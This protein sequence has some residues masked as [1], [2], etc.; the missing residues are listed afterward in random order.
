MIRVL[1][2]GSDTG[3]LREKASLDRGVMGLGVMLMSV[4]P[5][6]LF[7]KAP[8]TL[9]LALAFARFVAMV[10]EI[11]RWHGGR[12]PEQCKSMICPLVR[13]QREIRLE[14]QEDVTSRLWERVDA[15]LPTITSCTKCESA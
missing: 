14:Y 15:M 3:V 4:E 5:L 6:A 1:A 8:S 7:F 12:I 13:H 9:P 2:V 10:E 11:E